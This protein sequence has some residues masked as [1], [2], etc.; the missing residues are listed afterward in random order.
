MRA[1]G[2]TC[3]A[4]ARAL[5]RAST[6]ADV[7]RADRAR[8]RRPRPRDGD[9][10]ERHHRWT[11]STAYGASTPP[12]RSWD[13]GARRD[14]GRAPPPT[15]FVDFGVY[16][17]RGAMKMKAVRPTLGALGE[18]AV[19]RRPG[20]VLLELANA[21]APRTYD[22]QN[23]GSFMLSGTEAAELADRMAANGSCSFFHDSAKANGGG[24]GTL[25]K[26]F[27][28]EP[29]PDGS[30]GMFVNLTVTLSENRGQQ[31]FSVPVSY[32]ESAAIRQLLVYLVPRVLG[33]DEVF[34]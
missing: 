23:K 12:P 15:T 34:K 11:S 8:D 2:T 32:G 20:G 10:R 25:G 5:R 24:G 14:D 4:T 16:K 30:G 9:R 7:A 27:K 6:S 17:T 29:M 1:I 21:T 22:W 3:A 13:D 31:R 19:V 26:A 18:N 33:F 28:V